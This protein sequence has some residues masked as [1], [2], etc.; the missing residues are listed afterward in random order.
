[1]RILL[2]CVLLLVPSVARAAYLDPVIISNDG[3]AIIFQFSGDAGEPIKTITYV[4]Q[5]ATTQKAVREW[6]K[7]TVDDLNG[8][9]SAATLAALQPGQTVA[10]LNRT[11]AA[12]AA[13]DLWNEKLARYLYVKD[14]GIAAAATELAALKADLETTYQSGFLAP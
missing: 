13:K 14:S 1:M 7:D 5:A 6:V 3:K 12:R 4:V 9:R 10:R 8:I 11:A 2:L